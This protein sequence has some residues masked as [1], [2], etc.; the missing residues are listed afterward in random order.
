MY[1][2][3]DNNS[4]QYNSD[5]QNSDGNKQKEQNAKEEESFLKMIPDEQIFNFLND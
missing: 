1:H 3:F 4:T 2:I 5:R